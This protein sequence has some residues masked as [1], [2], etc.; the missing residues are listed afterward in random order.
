[1]ATAVKTKKTATPAAKRDANGRFTVKKK[2]TAGIAGTESYTTWEFIKNKYPD[3]WI[4]LENPV[5][6]KKS[7]LMPLKGILLCASKNEDDLTTVIQ[8]KRKR[9]NK[10]SDKPMYAIQYTGVRN[11]YLH[12]L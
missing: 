8:N 12:L 1:M 5:F 2:K 9:Q 7:A 6:E 10:G 4:L 11:K 3:H